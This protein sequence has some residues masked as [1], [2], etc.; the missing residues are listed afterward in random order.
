MSREERDD[1]S[2]ASWG[3]IWNEGRPAG[4]DCDDLDFF[5]LVASS[6]IDTPPASAREQQPASAREEKQP[7]PAREEKKPASTREEKQPASAQ[8][9][10]Q[11]ASAREGKQPASA[12]EEK[13]PP[14]CAEE[15]VPSLHPQSISGG[16]SGAESERDDVMFERAE[17][18]VE[19][20]RPLEGCEAFALLWAGRC[21][22][23]GEA[24]PRLLARVPVRLSASPIVFEPCGV[25]FYVAK[26]EEGQRRESTM[27]K[28][29]TQI[30]FQSFTNAEVRN[31]VSHTDLVSS[32][33][34]L[35]SLK[36][37]E[38]VT[39]TIA[40]SNA[41]VYWSDKRDG[42]GRRF[43]VAARSM[44]RR[45]RNT[46]E[47]AAAAGHPAIHGFAGECRA[48]ALSCLRAQRAAPFESNGAFLGPPPLSSPPPPLCKRPAGRN[49]HV[50]G[51]VKGGGGGGA[52]PRAAL[53]STTRAC[54]DARHDL[55]AASLPHASTSQDATSRSSAR[56]T[57]R[58]RCRA[59]T[60]TSTAA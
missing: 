45:A 37:H 7:A 53:L 14:P 33:T 43:G 32:H 49:T 28:H 56:R 11:P 47:G 58:T 44:S 26:R 60:T 31:D 23:D 24:P 2:A 12:R 46:S 8:E 36:T 3:S 57:G 4:D 20:N 29:A 54:A 35:S 25:T 48:R 21:A 13:P 27:Q 41:E 10:K 42:A 5:D 55:R 59:S 18:A 6:L 34:D 15:A 50:R 9:G 16:S 30:S 1:T 40:V 22:A 52:I 38:C 17:E 19:A 51:G 39:V